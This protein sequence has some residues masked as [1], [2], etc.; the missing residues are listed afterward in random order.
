MMM[1][2]LI[3]STTLVLLLEL[4]LRAEGTCST[5]VVADYAPDKAGEVDSDATDEAAC[6]L[7]CQYD[8][9]CH[10]YNIL[11]SDCSLHT[12]KTAY[13]LTAEETGASHGYMESCTMWNYAGWEEGCGVTK[14]EDMAGTECKTMTASNEHSCWY[15]CMEWPRCQA[16][17]WDGSACSL[18]S[19][20]GAA[21]LVATDGTTHHPVLCPEAPYSNF[22][23]GLLYYP[24]MRVAGA[25]LQDGTM[26]FVECQTACNTDSDCTAADYDVDKR[27][28]FFHKA[29]PKDTSC[30]NPLIWSKNTYHVKKTA[31]TTT[32]VGATVTYPGAFF[33]IA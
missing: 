28:C 18:C 12:P 5:T 15:Q 4:S 6:E 22:I 11:G 32:V 10:A 8:P 33:T 25:K 20:L 14:T 26:S 27:H 31:C 16:Y 24:M 13:R 2:G 21:T 19:D 23:S 29:T 3:W 1:R 9:T 17:D 7:A 30:E